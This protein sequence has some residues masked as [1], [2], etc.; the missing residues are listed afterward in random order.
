VLHRQHGDRTGALGNRGV[1]EGHGLRQAVAREV[2]REEDVDLHVVLGVAQRFGPAVALDP[3]P[4]EVA[5]LEG[6]EARA[7]ENRSTAVVTRR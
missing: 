3:R 4:P 1:G 5:Q 2:P 7:G 6:V